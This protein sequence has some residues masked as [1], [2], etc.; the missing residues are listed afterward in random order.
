MSTDVTVKNQLQ[1]LIDQANEVTGGEDVDLTS[2][3]GRLVEGY[4]SGDDFWR[5]YEGLLSY[6]YKFAYIKNLTEIPLLDTSNGTNFAYMFYDCIS[7]T[8]VHQFDL[9]NGLNFYGMFRGCASLTEL[10]LFDVSKGTNFEIIFSKCV[11]LKTITL[12]TKKGTHFKD[13]FWECRSLVS[14]NINTSSA[15]NTHTMF[16]YCESLK[17]ISELDLSK[18]SVCER[19]FQNTGA[20]EN[21]SFVKDSIK[22]NISF[23]YSPLLSDASI[24]SII[25]GLTDLTDQTSRKVSFNSTVLDKLTDGQL[26]QILAKNWTI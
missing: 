23:V 2:A 6:E 18:V 21:I 7:L 11:S 22:I 1:S 10:P 25:D 16:A 13:M 26:D 8:K 17:T 14:V 20:L 3:V 9:S 19:M 4:G 5:M 15:T 12:D 24:Q